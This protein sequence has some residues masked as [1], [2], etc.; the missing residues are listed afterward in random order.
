M[1]AELRV[2]AAPATLASLAVIAAL[3]V[4]GA[5]ALGGSR[6]LASHVSCGDT[7]TADTTLDSDLVNCPNNGIVIGADDITLNL[8]GHTIDGDG[9]RFQPCPEDEFCDVGL[10]NDGHDGITVRNGSVR[11]FALG[12]FVG[13]AHH[14]RV[15]SITS[16]RNVFFGF[17]VANSA[18]S[19][20]RNSSGSG[21]P[22]PEGDGIGLFGSHHIRILHNS[23]RNNGLGMHIDDSTNNSI[24]RNVVSGNSDFG[25][26]LEA[27]RNEVRRNRCVRN[28]AGGIVVGRG[29][30]NVIARN[31]VFGGFAGIGL[32]HGRRNVVAR[33]VVVRA[34][35][36][37]IYLGVPVHPPFGGGYNLVKG[38]R[39]RGT[40]KDGFVVNEKDDHSVLRRNIAKRNGDDGFDVESRSA[41]LTGNR[42]VRNADLGIEAVWGVNDGGGNV[43]RRNGDPRQCT[44]ISC[45]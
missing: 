10:L 32:E 12:A 14:I 15:L 2:R 29:G 37:G 9:R 18:R 27:D 8:N 17:V 4:G 22:A 28:G 19:L 5:V 23:F 34:D 33:N 41:T 31:R 35:R 25:I 39:A 45:R 6:A 24:R 38:N 36:A 42:A 1:S 44:H 21:N 7:I 16:S 3:A 40:G 11:Q 43:A 26:L 20:V 30:R 13:R